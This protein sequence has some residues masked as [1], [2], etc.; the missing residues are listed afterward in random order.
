MRSIAAEIVGGT[1]VKK[2][3]VNEQYVAQGARPDASSRT[4]SRRRT[5]VAGVATGLAYT[6]VGGDILFIEASRMRG[7]GGITL[8]GQIGDVMKESRHRRL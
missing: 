4:S 7:K 8:T 5:S 6:P 2:V 3:S 1:T